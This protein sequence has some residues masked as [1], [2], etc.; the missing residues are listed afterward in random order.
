M[1]TINNKQENK[2]LHGQGTYSLT[3]SLFDQYKMFTVHGNNGNTLKLGSTGT[4]FLHFIDDK[5]DIAIEECKD[6]SGYDKSAGEVVFF[7]S[8]DNA[9]KIRK[10]NTQSYHITSRYVDNNAKS[11]ETEL[12]TGK[13]KSSDSN[14]SDTAS[15]INMLNDEI[16]E[17]DALIS[18]DNEE[19]EKLR[20]QVSELTEENEKL[21]ANVLSMSTEL[22]SYK[23]NSDSVIKSIELSDY[24][25][26]LAVK[27]KNQKLNET[28]MSNIANSMFAKNI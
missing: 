17:K 8:A 16:K 10:M 9:K 4:M 15:Y 13:F 22:S 20:Q 24:I 21:K 18:A 28:Q 3:L 11:A 5:D 2:T 25:H 23:E 12:F 6:V 19:L 7:I 27:G 1:L 26:A 14:E